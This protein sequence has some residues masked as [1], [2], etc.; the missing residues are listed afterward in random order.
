METSELVWNSAHIGD[1]R[2]EQHDI[3]LYKNDDLYI[4]VFFHRQHSA[5]KKLLAFSKEELF[6][7]YTF[8]TGFSIN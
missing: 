3:L 2:D 5:I 1:R 6:D 4:E 7:I 8:K